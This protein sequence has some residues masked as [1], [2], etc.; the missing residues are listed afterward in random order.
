MKIC[1][2][3]MAALAAQASSTFVVQCTS[4]LFDQRADPVISSGTASGHGKT[5]LTQGKNAANCVV[6][7]ISGGNGFSYAM[8]YEDAR[9]SSCTTCNIKQDW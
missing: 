9:A 7:T 2:G 3:L 1:I 4:R 5:K 8:T 6:H